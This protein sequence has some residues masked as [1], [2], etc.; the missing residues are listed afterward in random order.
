MSEQRNPV[1]AETAPDAVEVVDLALHRDLDRRSD[2]ERAASPSLVVVDDPAAFSEPV[3]LREQ[4]AVVEVR[5]TVHHHQRTSRAHLA[6]VKLSRT[7]PHQAIPRR[8]LRPS[9]H[10]LR[11]YRT[12]EPND[13]PTTAERAPNKQAWRSRRVTERGRVSMVVGPPAGGAC[14]VVVGVSGHDH[15]EVPDHVHHCCIDC[16]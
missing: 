3:Q 6:H 14:C 2:C 10:R 5:A 15:R 9:R 8:P 13:A 7:A 16:G 4:V 11:R 1:E 12:P